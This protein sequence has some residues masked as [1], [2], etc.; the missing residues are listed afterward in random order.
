MGRSTWLGVIADALGHFNDDDGWAMASHVALSLLLALFPF[1]LFVASLAGIFGGAALAH[2]AA[3]LIFDAWPAEI[4]R[5]I[6][7]QINVLLTSPHNNLLTIGFVLSLLFA[8]SGIEALRSALNRAYRSTETR[9]F[10]YCRAQ[11]LAFVIVGAVLTLVL[12]GLVIVAPIITER[13]A[14]RLTWLEPLLG[15]TG[16]ARHAGAFSILAIT[17]LACHA[18]LPAGKRRLIELWP[19]IAMTAV[20]CILAGLGF[21]LYLQWFANYAAT[22]A[23][24]AGVMTTILFLYLIA[25]G[26]ILGG[27]FNAAIIRARALDVS[28]A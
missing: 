6:V 19:G 20:L 22:Y 10:W 12:A 21:A 25:V 1:L 24:L 16:L 2:E 7:E 11:S 14:F 5:P 3:E 18:I 4:A 28:E 9:P 27:E 15:L 23:G 13:I 8:S 17:L 26:I